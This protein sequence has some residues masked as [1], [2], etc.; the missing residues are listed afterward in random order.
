MQANISPSLC[1]RL[2]TCLSPW[3]NGSGLDR[4]A[5]ADGGVGGLLLLMPTVARKQVTQAGMA[6][7]I[8]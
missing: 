6:E 2:L 1:P 7:T 4:P 5:L 8:S 3:M